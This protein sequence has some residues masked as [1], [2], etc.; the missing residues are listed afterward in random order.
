MTYYGAKELAAAFRTV[1]SHTITIAEDIPENHYDFAA[2]PG[3]RNIRRLLAH[4]AL[5]SGV[6]H[7]IHSNNIDS[8]MN[9]NFPQ[10]MQQFGAEEA[11]PRTKAE[12]IAML[13]SEG[14]KFAAF[15]E[16][17]TDSFLE[18]RVAMPPGD[19][20]ATKSRFEMLLSPKEHEMHHRG[21]LMTIQRI[22]GVVPHL[23]RR[24]QERMAQAQQRAGASAAG[25]GAAGADAAAS[26]AGA[27]ASSQAGR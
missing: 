16:G 2:A 4:M 8:L 19:T 13:R 21:Q 26:G 23:T 17:L 20:V 25:A 9:V 18:E 3:T 7:H 22:L 24:M 10:L 27:S 14:D 1:R 12:L 11:K 6:Q 5:S 15:L